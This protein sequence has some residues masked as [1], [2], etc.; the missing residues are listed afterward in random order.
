MLQVV[1][2]FQ[3]DND[4]VL[5]AGDPEKQHQKLCDLSGGIPY[6]PNQIKLS[7]SNRGTVQVSCYQNIS[8]CMDK[9]RFN[10]ILDV[11]S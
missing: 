4:P 3:A 8:Q 9:H 10:Y 6:H 11:G 2:L 5:V 1:C 7:V